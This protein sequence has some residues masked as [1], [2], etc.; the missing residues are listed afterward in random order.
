MSNMSGTD[1]DSHG[2]GDGLPAL[3][4]RQPVDR[5]DGQAEEGGHPQLLSPQ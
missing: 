3:L 5:P 1:P 4:P 2:R